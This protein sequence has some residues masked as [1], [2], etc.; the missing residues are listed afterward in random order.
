M[1][2]RADRAKEA[3][4]SVGGKLLNQGNPKRIAFG[5]DAADTD[6]LNASFHTPLPAG[7]YLV[8]VGRGRFEVRDAR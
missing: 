1:K 8:R 2:T 3:I 5:C 6:D 7:M 4:A